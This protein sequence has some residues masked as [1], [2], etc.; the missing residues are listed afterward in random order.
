MADISNLIKNKPTT[1]TEELL[2][3]M[4]IALDGIADGFNIP[5]REF[6]CLEL[7]S[8]DGYKVSIRV[9]KIIAVK[10]IKTKE[11]GAVI[12]VDG[13]ESFVVAETYEEIFDLLGKEVT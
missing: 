1:C 11:W 2:L 10:E 13:G 3:H 6:D 8:T 12:Y 5:S 4:L 9:S 7:T